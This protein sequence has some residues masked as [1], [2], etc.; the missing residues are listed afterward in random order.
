[1]RSAFPCDCGFC[2]YSIGSFGFGMLP[3][4]FV[5]MAAM[6]QQPFVA[7]LFLDPS[8][9]APPLFPVCVKKAEFNAQLDDGP[10]T[11]DA[12]IHSAITI[13]KVLESADFP[14]H[15]QFIGSKDELF[16]SPKFL[17]EVIITCC[18]TQ[19]AFQI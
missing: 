4:P 11:H 16:Q 15:C 18:T 6:I 17:A 19:P 5:T 7:A 2:R 9:D 13:T 3:A 1:P 12:A 8:A 10:V 14:C